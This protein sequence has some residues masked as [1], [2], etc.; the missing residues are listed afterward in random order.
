MNKSFSVQTS[1]FFIILAV[2]SLGFLKILTPFLMD[3]FLAVIF[4][5]IFRR[6][7]YFFDKKL[8]NKPRIS[9]VLTLGVIV[10]TVVI[11]LMVVGVMVSMEAGDNY[12]LLVDNW[13]NINKGI[14]KENIL[15]LTKDFP[16][17]EE[18]ISKFDFDSVLPRIS[19]FLSTIA[20]LV[21]TLLKKTFFNITSLIINFFV[22]LFLL[23][24]IFID[25]KQ[26]LSKIQYLIPLSD[27]DEKN[28]FND[29]TKTTE[30]IIVNTF[31]IGFLEGTYGG[32]IFFFT[33][34]SSPFFWGI[35]MAFLSM[36]PL[37]G[38]NTVLLPAAIYKFITGDIFNGVIILIVGCGA[39]LIDQ[40]LIKPKLDG[41]RSGIHPAIVFISSMGGLLWLGIVGFLI[42]PLVAAI[43][44]SLWNQFGN[45]Y[46]E[47]LKEFNK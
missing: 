15:S 33:G 18:Y 5:I 29:I 10:F 2:V 6:V 45:N 28:L 3:I 22:I 20:D 21:F 38:A 19:Q 27:N 32:I 9:S 42:G 41:K 34:I 11:P 39:I 16:F 1:F 26:L 31:F 46:K 35:I 14:N 4:F 36:I 25:G 44:I 24:Y 43:F 37:L 30:A 40:N 12:Q 8:E 7:F 47:Q 17:L 13:P 23:Y